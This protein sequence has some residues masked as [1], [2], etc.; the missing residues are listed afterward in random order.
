[1]TESPP[2]SLALGNY[3]LSFDGQWRI[4]SDFQKEIEIAAHEI[5]QLLNE[6]DSLIMS[7]QDANLKIQALKDE[8]LEINST[9]KVALKMVDVASFSFSFTLFTT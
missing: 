1:M 7:L 4:K 2:I 6:R 9:N 3:K 8:I 5:N